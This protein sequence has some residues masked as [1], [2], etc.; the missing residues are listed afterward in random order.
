[1][2]FKSFYPQETV[3]DMPDSI[4]NKLKRLERILDATTEGWWEWNTETNETLQ[5]PG[6]FR[7]LGLEPIDGLVSNTIWEERI[8]PEDRML[9]IN[10][11]N[12]FI[13]KD[14]L[15]EQEFRLRHADG[16][17]LWIL[18]RGKVLHRST[19]GQALLV[20]GLNINIT[21][22]KKAQK[23]GEDLRAKENLVQGILKVSLSGITMYDFMAKRMS[24]ATNKIM[25]NL[26]YAEEECITISQNFYKSVLHAD[27]QS[28]MQDHLTK[29]IQ[30]EPGQLLECSLRFKSK[31]G[32]YHTIMLRDSVYLRDGQ[33]YPQEVICSAIDITNYLVLKAKMN[34]N[35]EFLQEMSFKNSHEM[36]AP[37][38]TMLGLLR[39]IKVELHSPAAV[40]EL[41]NYL[42]QTVT[43]MDAVIRE[44]T[45][46]LEEKMLNV[47]K[48]R[49]AGKSD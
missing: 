2:K 22:Q 34:D 42:D 26:G 33:G 37:V 7:M 28:K 48:S 30:S 24:F 43:K 27:D 35:F 15:W 12:H 39:L 23:L 9:A 5:G 41:I 3:I 29:L 10:N 49:K 18:S 16:S 4:E 20:G 8:H 17:Y 11:Q 1:M 46:T 21:A 31:Q 36:R 38:A 25:R 32:K 6:W 13:Q 19:N 44:L 14:E 47:E 45:L 40:E